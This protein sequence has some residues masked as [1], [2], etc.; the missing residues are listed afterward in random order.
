VEGA[1]LRHWSPIH[2]SPPW[3]AGR[4]DLLHRGVYRSVAARSGGVSVV[5]LTS[6][7]A[8][9]S[10]AVALPPAFGALTRSV[11][12]MLPPLAHAGESRLATPAKILLS[13]H[14]LQV[15]GVNATADPAD[16]VEVEAAVEFPDVLQEESDVRGARSVQDHGGF[17]VAGVGVDRTI[18]DPASR[19]VDDV[20]AEVVDQL[21]GRGRSVAHHSPVMALAEPSAQAAV[22]VVRFRGS[23]SHSPTLHAPGDTDGDR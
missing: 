23:A 5:A 9:T 16:V 22:N 13:G 18:P 8:R 12:S 4:L 3:L 19:V 20:P 14:W 15:V 21:R 7:V 1:L 2:L 17:S 10:S 11:H 6:P